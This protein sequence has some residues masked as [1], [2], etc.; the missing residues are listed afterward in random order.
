MERTPAGGEAPETAPGGNVVALGWVSALNDI[1]S[2]MLYAVTPIFLTEVIGA[3]AAVLGWVEGAA[4]GTASILKGVSGRASDRVRHRRRFILAGYSLSAL[5]KPLLAAATGWGHVLAARLLDRTGKGVR[6]APRD[7]LL[8]DSA[9]A[10]SRGRAFG[11]HRAMDSAGA[12][13]GVAISLVLL[14]V[15]RRTGT[16]AHA[17]RWLYAIAFVPSLASVLLILRVREV[18]PRHVAAAAGPGATPPLGRRFRGVLALY[19]VMS[20]G[21]SS[22]TFLLLRTRQV[23]WS[24]EAVVGAYLVFMASHAL[25][26]YPIGRHADRV[27]KESLLGVGMLVYAAVYAGFA[28]MPATWLVWPLFLAYGLYAALTEG[29]SKA[30]VS[31]LVPSAGR[32]TALGLFHMVTGLLMLVAS[33]VAG[34]LWDAVSVRAPFLLGAVLALVGAVGF[35]VWRPTR[36]APAD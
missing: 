32:G 27:R 10:G 18:R 20:L 1:S 26:S 9:P 12:V 14:A 5:S 15:L 25:L 3:S 34:W 7:A 33:A 30:L 31:D 36:E 35:L 16:E 24:A 19:G 6:T 13:I 28:W 4:E 17:F 8:A 11:L 2:E 23:G 29:V 22:D 21:L